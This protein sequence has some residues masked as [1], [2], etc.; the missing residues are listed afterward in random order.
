MVAN[1]TLFSHLDYSADNYDV[2]GFHRRV[3]GLFIS[4]EYSAKEC[5]GPGQDLEK[6][7]V[8]VASI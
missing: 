3:C 2:R 7:E 5:R 8:Y 6:S 1:L 4:T